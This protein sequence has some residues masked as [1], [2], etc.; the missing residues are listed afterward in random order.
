MSEIRVETSTD[1]LT[2]VAIALE[3]IRDL[4]ARGD[5]L[6]MLSSA[7][8]QFGPFPG[9]ENLIDGP[10][11]EFPEI[12]IPQSAVKREQAVQASPMFRLYALPDPDYVI[13]CDRSKHEESGWSCKVV[14]A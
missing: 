11:T 6:A 13:R 2:R 5:P 14:K 10:S 7:I 4:M 8:D 9:T 1:P 12:K 3:D